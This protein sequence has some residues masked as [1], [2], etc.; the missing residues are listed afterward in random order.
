MCPSLTLL[1][2]WASCTAFMCFCVVLYW[3]VTYWTEAVSQMWSCRIIPHKKRYNQ[4]VTSVSHMQSVSMGFNSATFFLSSLFFIFSVTSVYTL[5]RPTSHNT[6]DNK[7]ISICCSE[8]KIVA[9]N[10]YHVKVNLT[11]AHWERLSTACL[12]ECLKCSFLWDHLDI[13]MTLS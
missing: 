10:E 3:H 12:S 11:P 7:N 13:F 2:V 8:G 6:G 5:A 9:E 1:H 4:T